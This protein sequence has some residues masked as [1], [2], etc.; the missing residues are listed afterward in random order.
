[1]KTASP[2]L[3]EHLNTARQL[4]MADLYTFTLANGVVYRFTSADIPVTSGGDVFT[5]TALLKRTGT[6]C[7]IGISVDNLT[8]TATGSASFLLGGVN[9]S[10]AAVRGDFDR[11]TVLL[12]RAWFTDWATAPVGVLNQF[13]GNVSDVECDRMEVRI[14]VKS[15]L[16]RFNILMPRRVY[17]AGC[18]N[19][20]YDHS[21]GLVKSA[22]GAAGSIVAGSTNLRPIT[23]ITATPP[24]WATLGTLEF[25]SG[26]NA[27]QKRTVKANVGGIFELVSKLPFTPQI[28]DTLVAYPG[29]D[30]TLGTCVGKFNNSARYRGQPYIPRPDAVL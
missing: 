21:C 26:Q 6:Q 16:E 10:A 22:Y 2:A 24:G 18:P 11:A 30:K 17:Q 5:P 20:L 19:A 12:E 4:L 14:A 23:T 1:M 29:C 25:T 15:S 3:I 8:I 7:R 13:Q 28:G 27:G 9:F